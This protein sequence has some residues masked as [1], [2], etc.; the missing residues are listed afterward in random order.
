M[1]R[2]AFTSLIEEITGKLAGSVFQDSYGGFQIRTRVSPRNPQTNYQQLRR[3][4]FGF[5][6]SLWRSLDAGE[7]LSFVTAAGTLPAAQ[8]LFIGSNVNLTLVNIP[9]ISTYIPGSVPAAM[10]VQIN[11]ATSLEL[12]IQATGLLTTVPAG[13]KLLIQ[14]TNTRFITGI[15]L[16]PSMFSPT[17]D[18]DEGTDLSTEINI[19][20][21]WNSRY[22][23]LNPGLRLCIKAALIDK[24]NG[25]RGA[26]T[27]FCINSLVPAV[28]D[29][30]DFNG[31]LLIDSDGTFIVSQ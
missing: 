31:D 12:K 3:G 28:Y 4:E 15:F 9:I 26:E 2:V 10:S 18:F 13:T 8:D 5:I 23:V 29:I 1:A 22:G 19:I 14:A 7:R 24:I 16:N 17:I 25:T 30:S 6:S 20:S 27:I 11:S 21:A